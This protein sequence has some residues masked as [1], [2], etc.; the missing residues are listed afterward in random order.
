MPNWW[1]RRKRKKKKTSGIPKLT[2][3]PF[4]NIPKWL[5]E[6]TKR[7]KTN[8]LR[9]SQSTKTKDKK[10][11]IPQMQKTLM[12]LVSTVNKLIDEVNKI[13]PIEARMDSLESHHKKDMKKAAAALLTHA[14]KGTGAT[15]GAHVAGTRGGGRSYEK[16]GRTQPKSITR[17]QVQEPCKKG[18]IWDG[19]ECVPAFQQLPYTGE[20]DEGDL[21]IL[22]YISYNAQNNP[23]NISFNDWI[24]QRT[25]W[26]NNGRLAG[27]NLQII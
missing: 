27:A 21:S 3:S 23:D 9:P 10:I 15:G 20:Y 18:Y 16:G 19:T 7:I 5:Y 1:L 6:K 11:E 25:S 14:G 22:Q 24:S 13:P 4:T 17:S 2:G 26:W 12:T 8:P